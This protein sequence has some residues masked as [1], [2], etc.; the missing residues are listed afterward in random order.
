MSAGVVGEESTR[1]TGALGDET[2]TIEHINEASMPRLKPP[3]ESRADEPLGPVNISLAKR[4][5]L[6]PIHVPQIA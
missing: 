3:A 5:D 2:T 4:P 6:Y 1:V